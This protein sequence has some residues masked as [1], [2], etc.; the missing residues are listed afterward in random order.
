MIYLITTTGMVNPKLQN[1]VAVEQ[2]AIV[3]QKQEGPLE[4]N[5]CKATYDE[6]REQLLDGEITIE[7][8]Q[9]LWLEH[10]KNEQ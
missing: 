3:N 8:A 4:S 7:E 6:I 10:K 2:V 5:H 9:E 1:A